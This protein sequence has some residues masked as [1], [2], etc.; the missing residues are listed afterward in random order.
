[1]VLATPASID[2][3]FGRTPAESKI[4]EPVEKK[5]DEDEESDRVPT[6]TMR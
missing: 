4:L 3:R 5:E 6:V 1:M 2:G